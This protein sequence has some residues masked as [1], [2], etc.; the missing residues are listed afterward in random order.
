MLL[1]PPASQNS[2]RQ[3]IIFV[4]T[5]AHHVLRSMFGTEDSYWIVRRTAAAIP[6][7]AGVW[8]AASLMIT[9]HE[10]PATLDG[11]RFLRERGT[12]FLHFISGRNWISR[13]WRQTESVEEPLF[14]LIVSED[15]EEP[16]SLVSLSPSLS[17]NNSDSA[18]SINKY[19]DFV[20]WAVFVY[21]QR[22][23]S[24]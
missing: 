22:H 7:H 3:E 15:L 18:A 12:R 2:T 11:A 24:R 13:D 1:L 20:S 19:R 10:C 5:A 8:A 17:K 6:G 21:P 23:V 14:K 9:S 4:Q 16:L